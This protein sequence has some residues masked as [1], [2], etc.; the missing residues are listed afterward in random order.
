MMQAASYG[1]ADIVELL[2]NVGKA[3]VEAKNNSDY[4]PLMLAARSGHEE[5]VARLLGRAD[6]E[7][8]STTGWTPLI[9]AAA[10]GHTAT[11][12]LLLSKANVEARND[13]EATALTEAARKGKTETVKLLLEVGKANADPKGDYGWTP[14]MYAEKNDDQETAQ[15]LRSYI[16]QQARMSSCGN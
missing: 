13:S 12:K 8:K 10:E 5:V 3:D 15:L 16:D 2:I 11:V 9:I 4:T 14:L 7:A 6:I 1:H